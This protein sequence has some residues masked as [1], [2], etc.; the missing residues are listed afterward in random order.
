LG[1]REDLHM[2]GIGLPPQP[3]QIVRVRQRQYL[4]EELVPPP[5]PGDAT[6]VR[7]SC[8]DD[9]AQGEPLEVLWEMEVDPEIL[10]GEAW[11]HLATRGFDPNFSCQSQRPVA[12]LVCIGR[13]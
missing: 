7:L 13:S 1:T 10:T 8:L 4:T 9:D 6:L 12:V 2:T 3:G 11:D 5:S